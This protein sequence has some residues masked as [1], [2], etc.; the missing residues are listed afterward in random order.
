MADPT[1][2][3]DFFLNMREESTDMYY[4]LWHIRFDASLLLLFLWPLECCIFG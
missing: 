3:T 4:Y 1:P 2:I